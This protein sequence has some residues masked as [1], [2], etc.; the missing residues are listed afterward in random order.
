MISRIIHKRNVSSRSKTEA[1]IAIS[2]II[3]CS[4]AATA[5]EF[6]PGIFRFPVRAITGGKNRKHASLFTIQ[7]AA[8][9]HAWTRID[10]MFPGRVH[11]MRTMRRAEVH[12]DEWALPRWCRAESWL[13]SK[14]TTICTLVARSSIFT[15]LLLLLP[16]LLGWNLHFNAR[17]LCQ[18]LWELN[19]TIFRQLQHLSVFVFLFFFYSFLIRWWI[20][21][22]SRRIVQHKWIIVDDSNWLTLWKEIRLLLKSEAST[23]FFFFFLFY[24]M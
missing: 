21:T 18:T 24:I 19:G 20:K 2:L 3:V 1:K 23:F 5:R 10:L 15:F 4:A 11:M 17:W 12:D 9:N 16:R 6:H 14:D 8:V 22:Q 7:F 13:S